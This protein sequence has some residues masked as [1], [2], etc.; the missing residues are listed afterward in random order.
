M[1]ILKMSLVKVLGACEAPN[2]GRK[3]N[4]KTTMRIHRKLQETKMPTLM[5]RLGK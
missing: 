4:K 3:Q 2:A 1:T 5:K